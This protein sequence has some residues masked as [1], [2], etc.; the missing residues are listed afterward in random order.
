MKAR[1]NLVLLGLILVL[2]S[3]C[4]YNRAYLS[5]SDYQSDI[6][7]S[8]EGWKGVRLGKVSAKEGGAIWRECTSVAEGS[9]FVLIEKTRRLGGNAVGEIRWIPQKPERVSEEPT[10]KRRWGWFLVWPVLATHLFQTARVEG[11]AYRIED[12]NQ[13]LEG[14][15]LIPGSADGRELLVRRILEEH[16]YSR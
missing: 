6:P 10:C 8:A 14:M 7:L 15:Y 3:A 13:L 9:V 1:R 11:Q 5:Y 12:E 16:V 4:T 2:S